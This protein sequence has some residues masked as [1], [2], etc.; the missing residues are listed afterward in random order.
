MLDINLILC[1]IVSYIVSLLS[2][3]LTPLFLTH[4]SLVNPDTESKT[5]KVIF[6]IIYFHCEHRS[7]CLKMSV[8]LC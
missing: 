2:L 1:Y 4:I 5:F 8:S 6:I 7:H 3:S